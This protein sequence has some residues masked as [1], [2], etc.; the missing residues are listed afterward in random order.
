MRNTRAD[1][2]NIF[3]HCG[4]LAAPEIIIG[5]RT[6]ISSFEQCC[7]ILAIIRVYAGKSEVGKALLRHLFGM[8]RSGNGKIIFQFDLEMGRQVFLQQLMLFR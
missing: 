6:Q 8:T 7:D 3:E 4:I 2:I 5:R 1:G